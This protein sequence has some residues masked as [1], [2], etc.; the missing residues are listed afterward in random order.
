M[1]DVTLWLNMFW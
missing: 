1:D